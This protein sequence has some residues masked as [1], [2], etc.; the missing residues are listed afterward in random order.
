MKK[1]TVLNSGTTGITTLKGLCVALMNHTLLSQSRREA[2]TKKQEV[3][4]C[5]HHLAQ[6]TS[7]EIVFGF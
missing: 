1:I 5:F 7:Q 6:E 4:S 2:A 3:R